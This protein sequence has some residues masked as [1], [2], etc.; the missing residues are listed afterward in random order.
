MASNIQN[1]V[2][3]TS[4]SVADILRRMS[5]TS[6]NVAGSKDSGAGCSAQ[7]SSHARPHK[8][9]RPVS[10]S[11]T[12]ANQHK[13]SGASAFQQTGT[14][15]VSSVSPAFE[16]GRLLAVRKLCSVFAADFGPIL[17][18]SKKWHTH[19]E[20]WLWDQRARIPDA[21]KDTQDAI[22]PTGPSTVDAPE[23][24]HKLKR[25]GVAKKARR[26]LCKK[27]SKSASAIKT[28]LYRSQRQRQ[29]ARAKV[30]MQKLRIQRRVSHK[31]E[32]KV[33]EDAIKEAQKRHKKSRAVTTLFVSGLADN[34]ASVDEL[35]SLCQ[36][37]PG[38]E[39][40]QGHIDARHPFAFVKISDEAQL[41]PAISKIEAFAPRLSER[42]TAQL[43]KRDLKVATPSRQG[44]VEEHIKWSL[45]CAGV[46]VEINDSHCLQM[47]QRYNNTR[48][49]AGVSN[50]VT[51]PATMKSRT[52]REALFC[53]L[54][55]YSALQGGHP[56]G[57]G[58]QAA[59]HHEC[60]RV[61]ERDFGVTTECFASPFNA[62][63][64]F[65]NFCSMFRDTDRPFGSVGSF[66]DFH[67]KE[68][69]FEAN[70]PFQPP[71]VSM[72]LEHM[73]RLLDA[74]DASKKALSF[75]VIVPY[76]I[77]IAVLLHQIAVVQLP[78]CCV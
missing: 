42:Y 15:A 48:T 62:F 69:S 76:V 33:D 39:A 57:G 13:R 58:C 4:S 54:A 36:D 77:I 53:C 1:I 22:I 60:F 63:P 23:L 70:P 25:A 29:Q 65:R 30:V 74:A 18:G 10:R 43:A 35:K 2:G 56:R 24:E 20:A 9:K 45:T 64:G 40:L 55:R 32:A 37:L 52:F 14:S 49:A 38:F 19:F 28:A 21:D 66:F 17:G 16:A 27:L 68:G 61:L 51:A 6:S 11:D 75:I 71:I 67:P 78:L 8:R 72:M 26:R 46:S 5:A 41:A 31:E 44:S 34:D 12:S 47:L 50:S 3:H 59:I 73:H 7:V